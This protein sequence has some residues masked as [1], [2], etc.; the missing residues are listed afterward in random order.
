MPNILTS[1]ANRGIALEFARR[2]AAACCCVSAICRHPADTGRFLRYD[3]IPM[4]W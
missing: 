3:D 2:Y 4:P 1:G